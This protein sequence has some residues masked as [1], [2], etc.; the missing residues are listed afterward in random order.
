MSP[1]RCNI[2]EDTELFSNLI[3]HEQFES[4]GGNLTL[5]AL[6]ST[7]VDILRFYWHLYDQLLKVKYA[8]N[9]E[10]LIYVGTYIS[11]I[12]PIFSHL[13]LW[14]AV[15]RHNFKWLKI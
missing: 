10:T 5:R 15:A 14:I 13:K 12:T 6:M 1:V 4:Q 7:T 3:I 11:Q 8:F 2:S 9:F